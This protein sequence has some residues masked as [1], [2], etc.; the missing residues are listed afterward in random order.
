MIT[1]SGKIF[2]KPEPVIKTLFT[3]CNNNHKSLDR[4]N[5]LPAFLGLDTGVLV[6]GNFRFSPNFASAIKQSEKTICS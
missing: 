6:I 3:K 1:V 4:L 2:R 5:I